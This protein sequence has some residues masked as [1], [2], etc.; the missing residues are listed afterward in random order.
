M[1]VLQS[2]LFV[3]MT[4]VDDR[5]SELRGLLTNFDR[6]GAL[7]EFLLVMLLIAFHIETADTEPTEKRI[8]FIKGLFSKEV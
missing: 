3:L 1:L 4:L 7:V 5:C 2:P 8:K 6:L